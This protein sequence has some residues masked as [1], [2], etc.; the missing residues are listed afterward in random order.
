MFVGRVGPMP[1]FAGG[2]E[3]LRGHVDVASRKGGHYPGP[4]ISMSLQRRRRE[5]AGEI[6]LF[7][8]FSRNTPEITGKEGEK[9]CLPPVRYMR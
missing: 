6:I 4:A 7:A 5:C 3:P 1:W 2:A 8:K 9:G